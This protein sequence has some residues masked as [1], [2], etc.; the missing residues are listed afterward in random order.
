MYIYTHTC[1]CKYVHIMGRL[2]IRQDK[3]CNP[4]PKTRFG[5]RLNTALMQGTS[6]ESTCSCWKL[7]RV[8]PVTQQTGRPSFPRLAEAA[9]V[10]HLHSKLDSERR[11]QTLQK[12]SRGKSFVQ[13]PHMAFCLVRAF[14]TP[15]GWCRL[16]SASLEVNGFLQSIA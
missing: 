16:P 2:G 8:H 7:R 6:R 13:W 12:A 10:N 1:I 15:E 4:E 3:V 9:L 14:R 5:T 11:R